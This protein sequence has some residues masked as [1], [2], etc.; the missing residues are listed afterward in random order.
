MNRSFC[1]VQNNL[2]FGGYR[3]ITKKKQRQKRDHLSKE[4]I[5]NKLKK[6]NNYKMISEQI[7]VFCPKNFLNKIY[8]PSCSSFKGKIC[9]RAHRFY[10]RSRLWAELLGRSEDRKWIKQGEKL[11]PVVQFYVFSSVSTSLIKNHFPL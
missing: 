11:L 2:Q 10:G 4:I 9:D 7:V 1:R 5:K 8:K 6:V 3:E